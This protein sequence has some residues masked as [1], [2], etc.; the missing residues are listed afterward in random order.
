MSDANSHRQQKPDGSPAMS[1]KPHSTAANGNKR[2]R[3]PHQ[4]IAM[5]TIARVPPSKN[6]AQLPTTPSSTANLN[7]L[8]ASPIP[9]RPSP[10]PVNIPTPHAM[11]TLPSPPVAPPLPLNFGSAPPVAPPLPPDFGSSATLKKLPL[12]SP[13]ATASTAEAPKKQPIP[14]GPPNNLLNEIVAGKV[15]KVSQTLLGLGEPMP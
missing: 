15:L 6:L 2:A 13:D 4:D 11:K 3:G 7:Q 12:E 8:T 10:Q 14:S 9:S 1:A 5:P